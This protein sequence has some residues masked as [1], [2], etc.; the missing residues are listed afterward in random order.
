MRHRRSSS[1]CSSGNSAVIPAERRESRDPNIPT[2]RW[3]RDSAL[4][5]F[6][7]DTQVFASPLPIASTISV[8]C[9]TM[10]KT[11]R[12]MQ[13]GTK[14]VTASRTPAPSAC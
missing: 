13:E 8:S 4:G 3:I 1:R 7:D 10:T 5:G 2:F 11:L 9:I 6:R 12:D 14:L